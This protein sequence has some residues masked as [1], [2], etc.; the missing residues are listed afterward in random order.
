MTPYERLLLLFLAKHL[1]ASLDDWTYQ[2][3][4]GEVRQKLD[5]IM[6]GLMQEESEALDKAEP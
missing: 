4:R 5:E 3:T 6:R 2:P 1:H